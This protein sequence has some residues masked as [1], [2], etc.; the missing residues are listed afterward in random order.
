MNSA[1]MAYSPG[2]GRVKPSSAVFP[3]KNRCGICTRIPAPSPARGSAPTA[4][5]CSRFTR[6]VRASSTIWWDL[7]PLMSAMKPTP[8]EILVERGV[9]KSA[10]SGNAGI[11]GVADAPP[12]QGARRRCGARQRC[13]RCRRDCGA[14]GQVLS[15]PSVAASLFRHASPAGTPRLRPPRRSALR[16]EREQCQADSLVAS[17]FSAQGLLVGSRDA[18]HRRPPFRWRMHPGQ[19][20]VSQ[21]GTVL[22]S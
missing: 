22:L 13:A 12:W 14:P 11:G 15:R 3:A 5:R 17:C 9:V 10:C 18:P 16:P 4:P 19:D 20:A 8:Q 2:A 6:I 7:R 21:T 1:P